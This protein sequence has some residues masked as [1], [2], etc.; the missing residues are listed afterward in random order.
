MAETRKYEVVLYIQFIL[1]LL[2]TR[3][4]ESNPNLPS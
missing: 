4:G 2:W 1:L 3:C